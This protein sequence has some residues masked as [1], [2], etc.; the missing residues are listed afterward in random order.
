M[1]LHTCRVTNWLLQDESKGVAPFLHT[2]FANG[3][4]EALQSPSNLGKSWEAVRECCNPRTVGHAPHTHTSWISHG[5]SPRSNTELALGGDPGAMERLVRSVCTFK[6]AAICEH[7]FGVQVSR[8][9][10][11]AFWRRSI[12]ASAFLTTHSSRRTHCCTER[13]V[14]CIS[15]RR[16]ASRCTG[17]RKRR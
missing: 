10:L 14:G 16:F 15:L 8:S 9:L 17:R 5:G 6:Q 1:L 11:G 12:A 2:T 7:L 13:R 3:A 4:L